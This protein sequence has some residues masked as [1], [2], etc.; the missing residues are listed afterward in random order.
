M[1]WFPDRKVWQGGLVAVVS[2][3]VLTAVDQFTGLTFGAEARAAIT[4]AVAVVWQYFTP[5]ALADVVA[6]VDKEILGWLNEHPPTR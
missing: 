2:W 6:K 3:F 5:A 4:G 1:K